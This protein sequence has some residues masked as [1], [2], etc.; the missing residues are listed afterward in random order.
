M[1][2]DGCLRRRGGLLRRVEG[3]G[4]LGI[5]DAADQDAE[6]VT[7]L[8]GQPHVVLDAIGLGDLHVAK[9]V[10]AIDLVAGGSEEEH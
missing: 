3:D 10:G 6:L 7:L 2:S 8:Y 4:Q 1:L 5:A 9:V